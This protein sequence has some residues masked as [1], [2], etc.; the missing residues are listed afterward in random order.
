MITKS[1]ASKG[2]CRKRPNAPELEKVIPAHLISNKSSKSNSKND[3]LA[4]LVAQIEAAEKKAAAAKKSKSN[5]KND[6]LADVLAQIAAAEEK[7]E[8]EE[9]VLSARNQLA[10]SRGNACVDMPFYKNIHNSCYMDSVIFTLMAFPSDFVHHYLLNPQLL[11]IISAKLIAPKYHI[12]D[13]KK[14]LA[15]VEKIQNI[16]IKIHTELQSRQLTANLNNVPVEECVSLRRELLKDPLNVLQ[17]DIRDFHFGNASQEDAPEFLEALFRT[18]FIETLT[19]TETITY[20]SS[21]H[22]DQRKRPRV[23]VTQKYP[24]IP[25]ALDDVIESLILSKPV[26]EKL[27]ADSFLRGDENAANAKADTAFKNMK[28]PK[29]FDI[30]NTETKFEVSLDPQDQFMILSLNRFDRHGNKNTKAIPPPQ[31]IR[32]NRDSPELQL[33]NIIV[34]VGDTIKSGHYVAYFKCNDNW[35]LYN[36]MRD[37]IERIG[38]YEQLL[39]HR[40]LSSDKKRFSY[41]GTVKNNAYLLFYN[42]NDQRI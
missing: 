33:N 42:N 36:D 13:R 16:I 3:D 41:K 22:P 40:I 28:Y 24:V 38:T 9:A 29:I 6:D 14:I 34:H 19:I 17:P 39:K 31:S 25:I 20:E 7:A 27:D 5:S 37:I 2:D 15:Y 21:T 30:K 1:G 4:D 26:E 18:F 12:E 11:D 23:N 32:L 10:S 8:L 35:Y